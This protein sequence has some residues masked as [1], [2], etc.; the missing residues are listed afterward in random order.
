MFCRQRFSFRLSI[1][2][3][4]HQVV[5]DF[6]PLPVPHDDVAT[7]VARRKKSKVSYDLIG[8][9]ALGFYSEKRKRERAQ[10]QCRERADIATFSSPVA[11]C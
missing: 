11:R 2:E 8:S 7:L 9:L 4:T 3:I 5:S 6:F 10:V 1:I